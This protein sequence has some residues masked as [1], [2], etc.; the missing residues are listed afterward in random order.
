MTTPT[1]RAAA[2]AALDRWDSPRWEWSKH[3]PTSDL[4]NDLRAALAQPEA[5]P[6]AWLAYDGA[7]QLFI[8]LGN[9]PHDRFG[10]FPVY[11]SS[12]QR[13]PLSEDEQVRLAREMVKGNKSVEWLVRAIERAHGIKHEATD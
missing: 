7:K 3:G 6:V 9:G 10:G 4:M 12:P 1:L 2:Q 5:E 13:K 11:A 8:V